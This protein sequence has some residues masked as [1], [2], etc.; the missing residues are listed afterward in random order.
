[1]TN[2]AKR[3]MTNGGAAREARRFRTSRKSDQPL[4]ICHWDLVIP[5]VIR[6]HVHE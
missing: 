4:V 1:M 5:V 3:G 6:E 2:P